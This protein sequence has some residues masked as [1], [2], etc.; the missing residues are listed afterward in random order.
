MQNLYPLFGQNRILKKELLWSLRDISFA[1]LQLRYQDYGQGLLQGCDIRVCGDEL[2]VGPGLIK[3]GSFIFLLKEEERVPYGP[4]GEAQYL[5]LR[6]W[7][8]RSSP[9]YVA[10]R[11]GL[12]LETGEAEGTDEGKGSDKGKGTAFE[13]CRFFLREGARLRDRYTGFGDM[14]TAYDTVDLTH[15][16]WGGLGGRSVAPAVTRYLAELILESGD[17][18]PEDCAFAYLCLSCPGAVPVAALQ[19]FIRRRTGGWAAIPAET[20][21]EDVPSCYQALRAIAERF[22]HNGREMGRGKR[23]KRRIIID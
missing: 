6:I 10:Y 17:S 9:D 19:A 21:G 23:E 3:Y 5:R 14:E 16:D 13:L 20:Q 12:A 11:A 2:A 1:Q 15:A 18:Q 22:S 8:D 7:E 4:K